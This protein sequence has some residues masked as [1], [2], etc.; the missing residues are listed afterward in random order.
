MY[1]TVNLIGLMK[2]STSVEFSARTPSHHVFLGAHLDVPQIEERIY[3]SVL[4][5]DAVKL[6]SDH[7][8]YEVP[9]LL[10]FLFVCI[11]RGIKQRR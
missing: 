8:F 7:I 11:D 2:Q 9:Y 10:L 5:E 4:S 6:L 1:L 3:E